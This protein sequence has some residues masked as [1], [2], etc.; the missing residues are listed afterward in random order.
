MIDTIG[1][2]TFIAECDE[3]TQKHGDRFEVPELLRK[4]SAQGDSFY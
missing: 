2:D 1:I 3:L 4:M